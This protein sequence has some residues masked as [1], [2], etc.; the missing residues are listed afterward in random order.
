[1]FLRLWLRAV[2]RFPLCPFEEAEDCYFLFSFNPLQQ[3][4]SIVIVGVAD[5]S[6]AV[7]QVD[8]MYSL[9]FLIHVL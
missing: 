5:G 3:A 8:L 7:G 1:M 2:E 6:P 4:D 9:F